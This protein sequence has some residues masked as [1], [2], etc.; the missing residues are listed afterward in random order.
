[1]PDI[2]LKVAKIQT[3][4]LI[5]LSIHLTFNELDLNLIKIIT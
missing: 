3:F 1:M 5:N 2:L 4:G